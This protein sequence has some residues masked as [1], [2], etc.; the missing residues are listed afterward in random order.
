[1]RL[2]PHI[3]NNSV[4]TIKLVNTTTAVLFEGH[5]TWGDADG[6][7]ADV[8]EVE[9]KAG[10]AA[11]SADRDLH[12][13]TLT[14]GKKKKK[15]SKKTYA[16]CVPQGIC[17][18]LPLTARSVMP[19]RTSRPARTRELLCSLVKSSLIF[20]QLMAAERRVTAAL[21]RIAPGE[22]VEEIDLSGESRPVHALR[23]SLSTPHACPGKQQS[24]CHVISS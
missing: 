6:E 12:A 7:G 1:M 14:G 9:A 20:H 4:A 10:A 5:N 19:G 23:A 24:P 13:H 16:D 2:L 11:V 21:A 8:A 15:K 3:S 17:L 18:I 22:A